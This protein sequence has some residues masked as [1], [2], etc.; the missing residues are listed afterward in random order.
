M[1]DL[2]N[3]ALLEGLDAPVSSKRKVDND[4]PSKKKVKKERVVEA[5]NRELFSTL[6]WEP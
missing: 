2:L 6:S 4:E 5:G 1:E 3:K